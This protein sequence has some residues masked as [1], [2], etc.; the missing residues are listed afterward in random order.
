[1]IKMKYLNVKIIVLALLAMPFSTAFAQWTTSG[2]DIYFTGGNVGI[3]TTTPGKALDVGSDIRINNLT[4][5]RGSAN[6]IYSVAFGNGALAAATSGGY[7]TAIGASALTTLTTGERNV[8][9]GFYALNKN[10]SSNGNIGIGDY[11]LYNN[12]AQNNTAVGS[13]SAYSTTSGEQNVAIGQQA[14]FSNQTGVANTAIG[15]NSLYD[16][17]NAAFDGYNTAIGNNTGRGITTG[18][19]NTIIGAQVTGLSSTL[20]KNIIIADGQGNQRIRVISTGEVGIGTTTPA[21]K[22]QV[23][24]VISPA[25]DNT[26][27][28]GAAGYRFVNV[29]ATNGTIQ[30]S[31]AR[32]KKDIKDSNLGLSFIQ[33]LHPVSFKWKKGDADVHYGLVAQE[34]EKALKL[35]LK[36]E[37]TNGSIVTR[38]PKSGSYGVRY[39]ELIAPIIK[40]IQEL[41]ADGSSNSENVASLK[42]EINRL[43]QKNDELSVRLQKI[44]QYLENQTK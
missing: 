4:L 6:N 18:T 25:A 9:V 13:Q 10:V 1:M 2:S 19:Y 11:A 21:T 42:Q 37:F 22:L 28:L 30:T 14:L 26:Y 3:G 31:D 20:T 16:V 15:V 7:N 27:N 24:G 41:K 36:S 34:A 39:S 40:A 23:D 17:T 12:T 29:Y 43:N 5:G 32:E 8:A 35:N 38:D 33:S 44:E